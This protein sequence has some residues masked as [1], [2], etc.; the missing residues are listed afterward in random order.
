MI[1]LRSKID[2]NCVE[3]FE[4]RL[5]QDGF[6]RYCDDGKIHIYKT[7]L[8]NYF[9]LN[10][11]SISTI[12]RECKI[13]LI[14]GIVTFKF[15]LNLYLPVLFII[16]LCYILYSSL[17]TFICEFIFFNIIYYF[18]IISAFKFQMK[19]LLELRELR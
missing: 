19:N 11:F 14:K 13:D 10:P 16:F 4:A 9:N 2:P 12:F 1:N 8:F 17:F 7:S 18:L 5:F 6:F 15:G 3:K